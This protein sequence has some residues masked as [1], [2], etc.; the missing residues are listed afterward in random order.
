MKKFS[1]IAFFAVI[2]MVCVPLLAIKNTPPRSETT[3]SSVIQTTSSQTDSPQTI[4]V[5]RSTENSTQ[6]ISM[7]EYVCG[8]V[9][10]EM[11]LAYH[12]EAIK[13]QAVACYTNAL[14]LKKENTNK[15]TAHI[16][17]DTA[18]HQGYI[19]EAQRKEKW[20]D[21]FEKYEA[22]LQNAVKAVENQAIYYDG[23]LCVAAFYAISCG[24][25]EDAKS[26][27]G[28]EVPY[29]K[30]VSSEGD[31]LSPNYASA[32]AFEKN[33]FIKISKENDLLKKTPSTLENIIKIEE[34]SATGTVLSVTVNGEKFTGEEIRKIYSL[35]SPDFT[36]K[37]TADT[38]TFNVCGYGH[39]VGMSQ[40]GADCFAKQGMTYKE[41][42]CHYYTGIEI[43]SVSDII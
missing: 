4:A 27:W 39:G 19:D 22:K 13:A 6:N 29:L 34:K 43:T 10:A 28:T 24:M 18:V 12:E 15:N 20:G 8:S 33:E 11:P 23:E 38:V 1:L 40:Y 16:S 36:I 21:D 3:E 37:T 42:L 2:S 9:A 31:K 35:R 5:F 17:D 32:V 14:R 25:T 7:F 26:L 41:I 30:S